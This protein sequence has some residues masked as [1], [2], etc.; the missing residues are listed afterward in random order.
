MPGMNG[1]ER[2]ARGPRAK[3]PD[4]PVLFVTGFADR[5]AI[6]GVDADHVLGKPFDQDVLAEKVRCVLGRAPTRLRVTA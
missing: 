1:A 5:A 6:A 4:L 3:R 2:G